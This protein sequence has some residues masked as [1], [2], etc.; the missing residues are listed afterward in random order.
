MSFENPNNIESNENVKSP[1]SEKIQKQIDDKKEELQQAQTEGSDNVNRLSEDVDLLEKEWQ[2][3]NA[4][5]AHE[6]AL[7]ASQQQGD[8]EKIKLNQDIIENLQRRGTLYNEI[9][10]LRAGIRAAE[11]QVDA[12]GNKELIEENQQKIAERQE[13]LDGMESLDGWW[14]A[15]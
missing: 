11:I 14:K 6:A 4:L 3:Q 7:K 10:A 5:E 9:G 2:V 12:E 15:S 13:E 1:L 8:T